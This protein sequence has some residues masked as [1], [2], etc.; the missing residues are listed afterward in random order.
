MSL[1]TTVRNFVTA[2]AKSFVAFDPILHKLDTGKFSLSVSAYKDRV[3]AGV[4]EL[5]SQDRLA[6]KLG[7]QETSVVKVAVIAGY[8]VAAY[9]TAGLSSGLLS[10]TGGTAASGG[11]TAGDAYEAVTVAESLNK[12]NQQ[13]KAAADQQAAQVQAQAQAAEANKQAAIAAQLN[14]KDPAVS[15]GVVLAALAAAAAILM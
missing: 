4:H 11:L 14:A 2:P 15:T 13:K 9:F 6:Q 12:A 10:S 8:V 3:A 1:F 7:I 5:Y